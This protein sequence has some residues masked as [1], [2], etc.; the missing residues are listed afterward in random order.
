MKN[1][2]VIEKHDLEAS[3]TES[4]GRKERQHRKQPVSSNNQPAEMSVSSRTSVS[5]SS[6]STHAYSSRSRSK[7]SVSYAETNKANKSPTHN[8][9]PNSGIRIF[10][11]APNLSSTFI[12]AFQMPQNIAQ[13]LPQ[14]FPNLNMASLPDY[15]PQLPQLPSV[16]MPAMP[17]ISIPN[18]TM[19]SMPSLSMPSMPNLSMPNITMPSIPSIP[20]INIPSISEIMSNL[21]CAYA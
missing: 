13:A 14:V 16:S 1:K 11:P 21:E 10:N 12:N 4:E 17:I 15:L 2:V 8:E 6:T 7:S 19:P 18:I 5:F 3:D 20:N 9:G